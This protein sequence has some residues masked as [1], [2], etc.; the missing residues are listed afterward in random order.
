M[1][2][3]K[4]IGTIIDI[5]DTQQVSDSFK[6]REVIIEERTYQGDKEY[7]EAIP[8]QFLQKRTEWLDAY[9][10]GETVEI[11]AFASGRE[12]KGKYFLSLNGYRI[13]RLESATETAP[14]GNSKKEDD[15]PF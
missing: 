7:T 1:A 10:I 12:W 3:I 6:K 5:M 2:T 8:I 15:L 11:M 14:V 4:I 13:K 9:G